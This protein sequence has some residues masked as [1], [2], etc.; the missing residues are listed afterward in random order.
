[1]GSGPQPATIWQLVDGKL[2]PVRVRAGLS[3]GTSVAIL[4]GPL[5]EGAQIVTSV[6]TP[7]TAAQPQS[8]GSPLMPNMGRGGR[9]GPSGPGRR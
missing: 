5:V 4:G 2:Q 9:G 8:T 7:Q 6:I 1:M 3:D